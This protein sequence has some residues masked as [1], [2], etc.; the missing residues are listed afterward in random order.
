MCFALQIHAR[1]IDYFLLPYE[2]V[3]VGLSEYFDFANSSRRQILLLDSTGSLAQNSVMISAFHKAQGVF[4]P[5]NLSSF[6][7]S[8]FKESEIVLQQFQKAAKCYYMS[9]A[10]EM[11]DREAANAYEMWVS[12]QLSH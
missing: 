11:I 1:P 10:M 3:Y 7:F 4:P 5:E 9:A 2:N 6:V 12:L 8:G